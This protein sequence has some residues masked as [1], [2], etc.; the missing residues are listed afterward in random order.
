MKRFLRQRHLA[1]VS[2]AVTSILLVVASLSVFAQ[3][4]AITGIVRGETGEPQ[5][6]VSVYEK[7]TSNG[8]ISDASGAFKISISEGATLVFSSIG[9]ITQEISITNQTVVD[10]TLKED[11]KILDDVVV[12]GYGEQKRSNVTGAVTSVKAGDLQNKSQLRI[13]QALQGMAAGVTVARDG[14]APGARPSIHIRGAGSIS[15]TDP[16]WI[17][18]GVRMDPGNQFDV[19]DVESIE[20]LKDAAAGAIYGIAA[21]HGVILVTT[22]R[23]KGDTKITFK[24]S[25]SKR[26]PINLP[27]FLN[28]AD[29]VTYRKEGRLNA[30]QNPDPSWDDYSAD[31]DWMGAF[32][33]GSGLLQSYDL[34]I[35]KGDD[36]FTYYLSFGHDNEDGILI[37]NNFKRYSLRLNTDVKLNKWFKIGESVLLSKVT[38]NPIGNNN[39]NYSGAIPFRSIPIMPIY[40][41]NNP[42][43]GWG[44]GPAYFNGPNPVATQYQQ[45]EEKSHN[46]IDGN[47]YA[48]LTPLKGL[49]I[50]GTVG[51]NFY[52][53]MTEQ[54]NE[55]FDYGTFADPINRLFYFSTA[56]QSILGNVVATYTQQIQKHNFK[57]MV[58]YEANKY[59]PKSVN[60]S[61]SGF[62]I[63]QAQSFNL[64]SGPISVPDPYQPNAERMLSEFG[65]LNYSYNDRYLLE[66][67]LRHDAIGSK[68]A[69]G[70]RWG[71]FPS[72]SAGWRISEEEFFKSVSF[73]SNL[74]LRGSAGQLG[75]ANAAPFG[76]LPTY[77]AQFS[78]YS[79]DALGANKVSGYYISRFTNSEVQWEEI[80]SYNVAV[81][82]KFLQNKVSLTVEWYRRD[83][84]DLLYPIPIPASVG[85]ATHNF[86]PTSPAVNIGTMRN[87]GVDVELG[88]T[89]TFG[90]FSVTTSGNVSYLKNKMLKLYGDAYVTG[91]NGGG[92]IGGMTR[93]QPGHPISSFYGYVVQQMLN[94]PGDVFAINTYA[95][96]GIYQEAGTGP[97]DFMYKDLNGDGEITPDGDRTFIGNPWPKF[98]YALNVSVSYKG[99]IDL[100][101][102]F[103]GIAGVDVFNAGKAYTRNFFGDNNSTTDIKEAWTPENRTNHPRNIATDPNGNFGRPSTYFV[104]DG[105]YLKLRNIQLGFNMPEKYLSKVGIKKLRVYANANNF[106]T[107]TKY[108]GFDPEIAGSNT[109]RGV[110]YGQYPQVRTFGAGLEL[111]F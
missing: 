67:N 83:T 96:D 15:G 6:G 49:T 3:T 32:Y 99:M 90:N 46:R 2:R 22:K 98:T 11:T 69:P 55:A 77:T 79:F 78:R 100:S 105:S 51:Y 74:K 14:G 108:S 18:D 21:A 40:D 97:G 95:D 38:E 10:V 85:I 54:F 87:D 81:D 52:S 5:P 61:G 84:K 72:L 34:S 91:G 106:L 33:N 42:Y 89:E 47:A 86:D 48:E 62:I 88:Y 45:H 27:T 24:S 7:G 59:D 94:T 65:R 82:A 58:G 103:Q 8:T 12:V 36:K 13:D 1:R 41:E 23:G 70:H 16:L 50:R 75:S 9:L 31:T 92:Q 37:D 20:I 63:D 25:I 57:V 39:E 73:V 66:F 109:S 64:S 56:S 30:G 111:Q 80:N 71:L 4:K 93:T 29:F 101:L 43:G 35:S 28:S 60:A 17:V 53:Y 110:D 19:D 26:Q 76:W 68:F 107:F 102:Q 44:M 104:E